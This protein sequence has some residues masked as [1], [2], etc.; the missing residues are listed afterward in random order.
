MVGLIAY[1]PV[2]RHA[3]A[4]PPWPQVNFDVAALLAREFRAAVDKARATRLAAV[5]ARLQ[6][7]A[8]TRGF[9]AVRRLLYRPSCLGCSC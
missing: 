7:A 5:H 3:Q 9:H 6:G 8:T 2:C 1:A 4:T